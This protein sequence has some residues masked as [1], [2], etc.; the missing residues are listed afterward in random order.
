M[1][2]L[3][4]SGIRPLVSCAGRWILYHWATKGAPLYPL[5]SV[6]FSS[7][8]YL[9]IL[10]MLCNHHHYPFPELLQHPRQKLCIQYIVTAGCFIWESFSVPLDFAYPLWLFLESLPREVFAPRESYH[11]DSSSSVPKPYPHMCKLE[12]SSLK[13]SLVNLVG[14]E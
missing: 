6:R 9:S 1:W 10:V 5:L 13:N 11:S 3:P 2:D 4:G 8:K 12:R 7:V 14:V